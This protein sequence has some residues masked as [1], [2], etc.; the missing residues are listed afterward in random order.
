MIYS[1]DFYRSPDR[2]MNRHLVLAP[3]EFA[4]FGRL[5]NIAK[6]LRAICGDYACN[7][8][9]AETFGHAICPSDA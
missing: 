1:K 5:P 8:P 7:S 3:A 2:R 6:F 4:Q 9:Q